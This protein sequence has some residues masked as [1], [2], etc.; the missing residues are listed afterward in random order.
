VVHKKPKKTKRNQ[1]IE[2]KALGA[3]I[4]GAVLVA[5][6]LFLYFGGGLQL[7]S[8]E[9]SSLSIG[10]YTIIFALILLGFYLLY[11]ILWPLK[12]S[13]RIGILAAA[14]IGGI[15]LLSPISSVMASTETI[16][17]TEVP[18]SNI[19][20][21]VQVEKDPVYHTVKALFAGGKG[22]AVTKTCLI[23]VTRSDGRVISGWLQPVL[24][25]EV[26][27]TGTKNP[28]RVE[29][30]VMYLSGDVYKIYDDYLPNRRYYEK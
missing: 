25:D 17:Y 14:V 8:S 7:L 12:S 1:N 19:A 6:L 18:P 23:R 3:V 27:I 28:D 11:T 4:L 20:V 16:V 9:L 29:V 15:F 24:L 22:Q 10:L 21:A 26:K 30:F 5:L 13:W 2:L